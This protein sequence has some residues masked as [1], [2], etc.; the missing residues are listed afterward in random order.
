M[1]GYLTGLSNNKIGLQYFKIKIVT[2]S[3]KTLHVSVQILARF[4]S[5]NSVTA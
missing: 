1:A 2:V 3:A 5:H 4:E